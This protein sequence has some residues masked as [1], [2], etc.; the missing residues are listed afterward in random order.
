MA[1]KWTVRT[2]ITAAGCIVVSIAIIA[3]C[4]EVSAADSHVDIALVLAADVSSSMTRQEL[5]LQREGYAAALLS[6]YF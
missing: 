4:D 5:K 2:A 6:Q 1:G 3:P